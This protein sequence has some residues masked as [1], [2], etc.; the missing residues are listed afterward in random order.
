VVVFDRATF[1]REKAC[2]EYMSPEGVRH[3]A[4]LGVLD[5]VEAEGG[6]PVR[7]TRV[8]A[9]HGSSLTGLFARAGSPFRDTGLSIPRHQLDQ[10]L[11]AAARRA[12]AQVRE[13]STVIGVVREGNRL[14]GLQ[15]REASGLTR[16]V[17]A[18]L[19]I[20][21]DGLRSV[22]ARAVGRR[23]HGRLRRY[24]LVAHVAG[25]LDLGDTAELHVSGLGYLGLNPI[26]G[27][28]ANLALV[29][30]R[31]RMEGLTRD[32]A[33]FL[34]DQL[35][36]FP[37]V[38]GRVTRD[39]LVRRVLATGPFAAWTAPVTAPGGLLLGDAADF[40][41]PFTGEGICAALR[42]A[43]LVERTMLPWLAGSTT[44]EA[45]LGAY[46]AARRR[47]F[48][49][50]WAVERLI[51]YAML[52]PALFDRAVDRLERR[53]LS[54]TLIGVTGDYLPARHV[55]NPRFLS[56]VML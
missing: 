21:A 8:Y 32:P 6:F 1:P 49:G 10:V 9:P 20:G 36:R 53:G 48:T 40:F 50:K 37:G 11:V 2:S 28:L 31:S 5:A 55:L 25:V 29:L 16:E 45:G 39:R 52:A 44:H 13:R 7:G 24:A 4:S 42:G 41:D 22:T 47:A 35:E 27:G 34:F 14:G 3:L 38:R 26:G 30:P 51:G 56:Q 18:R 54:H 17:R 33:P 12:G 23:R 46:R 15:V 43:E 19:V